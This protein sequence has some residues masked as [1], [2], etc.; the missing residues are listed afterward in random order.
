[1]QKQL[2]PKHLVT[3]VENRLLLFLLVYLLLQLKHGAHR[4]VRVVIILTQVIAVLVVRG[5][6]QQVS[7]QCHQ[8]IRFT[9][10]WAD[11]VKDK[12]PAE[13]R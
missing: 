4:V 5:D 9:Y 12:H 1:M 6:I 11:K 13:L 7:F 2:V 10:M 3:Q 8:E